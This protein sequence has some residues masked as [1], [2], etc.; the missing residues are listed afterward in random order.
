[1]HTLFYPHLLSRSKH[2][3][4]LKKFKTCD[5]KIFY[6]I[7]PRSQNPKR[8]FG[9]TKWRSLNTKVPF[10][11]FLTLKKRRHDIKYNDTQQATFSIMTL[12]T[13]TFS[14]TEC[15]D[16]FID[17]LSVIMLNVVMPSVVTPKKHLTPVPM[18]QLGNPGRHVPDK[19]E[20]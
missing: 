16:L 6:T 15:R 4:L 2:S 18:L 1:M 11:L 17:M 19:I 5:R 12:S 3:S 20:V 14:I 8:F 9:K 10:Y 13:I 7:I